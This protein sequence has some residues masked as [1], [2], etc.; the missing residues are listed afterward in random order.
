[1]DRYPPKS[2]DASVPASPPS[3]AAPVPGSF[4]ERPGPAAPPGSAPPSPTEPR[5]PLIHLERPFDIDE[6]SQLLGETAIRVT[7]P[8]DALPEVLRR[9]SDFMGFGIYVY[10]FTVRPAPSELLRNYIVELRRVDYSAEKAAWVPFV[11]R[12]TSD[13]PFGPGASG[14]P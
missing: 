4:P 5:S 12:G 7:V 11:E 10:E 3:P 14:T 8:R 9:I 6:F 13:S 2:S 1:M